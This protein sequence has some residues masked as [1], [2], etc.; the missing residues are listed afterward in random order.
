MT[1]INVQAHLYPHNY[2]FAKMI[3]NNRAYYG[4]Y[5]MVHVQ[6]T[7]YSIVYMCTYC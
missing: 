2:Y 5:I 3:R 1:D 7:F 4:E 6:Y